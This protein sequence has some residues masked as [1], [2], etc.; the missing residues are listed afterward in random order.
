MH[1]PFVLFLITSEALTILLLEDVTST[2]RSPG[3]AYD[4]NLGKVS[5][6][7]FIHVLALNNMVTNTICLS[8]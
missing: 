6:L 8:N 7:I 2:N 1:V 4:W 3:L 5:P